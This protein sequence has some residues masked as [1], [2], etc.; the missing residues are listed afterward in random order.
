MAERRVKHRKKQ[1]QFNKR[2]GRLQ[3]YPS[4]PVLGFGCIFEIRR[5][6][7]YD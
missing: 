6:G 7:P 1:L 5:E 4:E 2:D 3:N